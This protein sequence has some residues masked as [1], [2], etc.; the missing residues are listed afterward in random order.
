[1]YR[2]RLIYKCAF[3]KFI[4]LQTTKVGVIQTNIC[5]HLDM[6]YAYKCLQAFVCISPQVIYKVKNVE[7]MS[8]L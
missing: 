6:L 5:S 2:V 1:M 3:V 7:D 4:E 8:G